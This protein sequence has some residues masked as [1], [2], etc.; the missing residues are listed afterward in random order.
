M[1]PLVWT[2]NRSIPNKAT[3]EIWDTDWQST[4]LICA[5]QKLI[6]RERVGAK[7]I[8]RHVP[9]QTLTS[10]PSPPEWYP[11]AAKQPSPGP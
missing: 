7:V 6:S 11:R 4:N 1:W 10:G 9:A 5:Q 3:N 8:K 2:L